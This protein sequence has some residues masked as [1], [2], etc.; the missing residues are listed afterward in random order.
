MHD[1]RATEKHHEDHSDSYSAGETSPMN[2][3]LL[4]ILPLAA[5]LAVGIPAQ[6]PMGFTAGWGQADSGTTPA[7]GPPTFF[8][9]GR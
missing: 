5:T 8:L 4:L 7:H 1:R 2:P 3:T 9:G 6:H